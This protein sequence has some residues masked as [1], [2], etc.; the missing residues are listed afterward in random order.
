M[1]SEPWAFSTSEAKVF[2][3]GPFSFKLEISL[4]GSGSLKK[5]NPIP[6]TS[7]KLK[8]KNEKASSEILKVKAIRVYLAPTVFRD[9]ATRE[10]S[11]VPGQWVTKYFRLRKEVQPLLGEKGYVEI[12]FETFAI[13]FHPRERKFHGPV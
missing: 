12:T 3:Q 10:F 6:I 13:Q 2:H 9:I 7:L 8:M 5:S 4:T 1:T 11:V